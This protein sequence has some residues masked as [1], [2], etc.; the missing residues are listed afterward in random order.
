M[1]L[2]KQLVPINVV[3]RQEIINIMGSNNLV[4]IV[5]FRCNL[6]VESAFRCGWNSCCY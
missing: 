5:R 6:S 1:A 3:A 4:E 2:C